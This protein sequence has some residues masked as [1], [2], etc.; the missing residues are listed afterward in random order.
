MYEQKTMFS[1]FL[2]QHHA[3]VAAD[4]WT[5]PIRNVRH[6]WGPVSEDM[7]ILA[8]L[9][10]GIDGPHF[11]EDF[12]Y[13]QAGRGA[14]AAIDARFTIAQRRAA[15]FLHVELVPRYARIRRIV[16]LQTDLGENADQQL[17]HVVIDADG[18]FDELGFVGCGQ[19]GAL[20]AKKKQKQKNNT[21]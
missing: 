13:S 9:G 8:G 20:C 15:A 4:R 7:Q 3:R 1:R 5:L 2:V 11:A 16:Q 21:K 18:R 17:V 19:L 12:T 10:L 14:G 6:K